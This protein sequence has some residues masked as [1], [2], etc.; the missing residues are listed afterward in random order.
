MEFVPILALGTLVFTFVIFLKNLTAQQWRSAITQAIAWVAGIAG[1]LIMAATQFAGGISIGNVAMD[2]LDFWSK[3]FVG[4]LAA[5]L[6][7]TLNEFKK[8]IDRTDT[9]VVPDWFEPRTAAAARTHLTLPAQ[10]ATAEAVEE[11]RRQV[12]GSQ[13][14]AQTPA[15]NS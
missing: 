12:I 6:L 14:P 2:K 5:S 1:V 4:L 11:A 9:A 7:S 15:P 3:V 8:A 10:I 13:G